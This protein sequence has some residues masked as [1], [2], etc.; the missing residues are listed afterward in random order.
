MKMP[1]TDSSHENVA[2]FGSADD[3][4]ACDDAL[5]RGNAVQIEASLTRSVK[6]GGEVHVQADV[7]RPA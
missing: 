5:G 1:T 4:T 6:E 3:T 2:S 7:A